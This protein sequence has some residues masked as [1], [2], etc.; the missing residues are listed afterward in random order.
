MTAP[1]DTFTRLR[2]L[3]LDQFGG[4]AVMLEPETEI[5]DV[6]DDSLDQVELLMA[7]EEQFGIEVDDEEFETCTTLEELVALIDGRREDTV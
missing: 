6:L 2:D 1:A 4:A 5:S 7:V 3:M